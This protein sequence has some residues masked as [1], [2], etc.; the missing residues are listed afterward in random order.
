MVIHCN[1]AQEL[2]ASVGVALQNLRQAGFTLLNQSVLLRGINDELSVQIDLQKKL[3][4]YGVLPYYL[5]LLDHAQGTAHFEVD[6]AAAESLIHHMRLA[7]PGYLVPRLA[8]EIP[9]AGS[10]TV[11]I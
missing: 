10:K 11:F 4:A 2:D 1:H 6:F 9:G 3:F 8:R 7:L 5:H